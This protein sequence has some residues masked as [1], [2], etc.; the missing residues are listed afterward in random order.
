MFYVDWELGGLAEDCW[1][2]WDRGTL[3]KGVHGGGFTRGVGVQGR[4]VARTAG[5]T[6]TEA[7]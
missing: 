5:V 2:N 6:G 3:G 1:G 7:P 4:L